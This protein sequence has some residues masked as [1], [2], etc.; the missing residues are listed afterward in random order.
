MPRWEN[1]ITLNHITR[2]LVMLD[3]C[4]L[5]NAKEAKIQLKILCNVCC[6][7]AIRYDINGFRWLLFELYLDLKAIMIQC[8]NM[9]FLNVHSYLEQR[10]FKTT[11]VNV[12]V[13]TMVDGTK[14]K[15]RNTIKI[16]I[17]AIINQCPNMTF[18]QPLW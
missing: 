3:D 5:L 13:C 4:Y 11:K 15:I 10:C 2:L 16:N 9:T 6:V 17:K 7:R 1:H 12:V 14:Y 18:S 8:P